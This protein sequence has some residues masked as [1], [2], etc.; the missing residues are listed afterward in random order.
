MQKLKV[1]SFVAGLK[2]KKV[3]V[4]FFMVFCLLIIVPVAITNN[5]NYVNT[6]KV[7]EDEINQ[8]NDQILENMIE[9]VDTRLWKV[10]NSVASISNAECFNNVFERET[11]NNQVQLTEN[12]ITL[13]REK[14][15][16][17]KKSEPMIEEASI[18][19]MSADA[20]VSNDGFNI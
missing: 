5:L 11:I 8:Y 20:I 14:L 18:Y 6:S 16:S 2:Q 13:M 12:D 9:Y 1:L 4:Q 10:C 3:L 15:K 17:L 7:I 19:F